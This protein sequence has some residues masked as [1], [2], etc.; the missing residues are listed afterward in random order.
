MFYMY[1]YIIDIYIYIYAYLS[2]CGHTCMYALCEP[3]VDIKCLLEDSL[4]LKQ[5][6]LM[7]L[8]SVIL[9]S[10]ATHHPQ[11]LLPLSTEI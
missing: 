6:L 7:N 11:E 10:L 5:S 3:K 4:L 9:A 1:V 2:M 8:G